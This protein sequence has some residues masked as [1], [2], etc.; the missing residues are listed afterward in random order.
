MLLK[1]SIFFLFL[2]SFSVFAQ[3]KKIERERRISEEEMPEKALRLLNAEKPEKARR[4]KFYLETDG[5]KASYEAKFKYRGH[6]YSVE[7]DTL[8]QL[9]DIE[10]ELKNRDLPEHIFR[11]ITIYLTNDSEKHKIEKIQAQFVTSESAARNFQRSLNF[12]SNKPQN[13][14]VIVVLKKDDQFHK[15]EMLF[16]DSGKFIRKREITRNNYDYIIY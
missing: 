12:E 2:I 16:D 14:E 7:F 10:V 4:I 15:F 13:Y 11:E 6:R 9:Q 8:G 1:K 3:N 5:E